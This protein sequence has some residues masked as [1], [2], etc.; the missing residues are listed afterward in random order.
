MFLLSAGILVEIFI[1]M[2]L[3][4]RGSCSALVA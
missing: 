4:S 2:V 1:A 3:L